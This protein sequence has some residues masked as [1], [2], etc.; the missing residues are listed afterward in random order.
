M[1][2]EEFDHEYADQWP[3]GEE[4]IQNHISKFLRT[5]GASYKQER[6]TKEKTKVLYVVCGTYAV[7]RYQ[8]CIVLHGAYGRK[9]QEDK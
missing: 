2:L 4:Y 5:N 8:R 6:K 3:A 9:H 1:Y 7:H